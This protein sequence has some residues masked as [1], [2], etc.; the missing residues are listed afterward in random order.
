M[1]DVCHYNGDIY[2]YKKGYGDAGGVGATA[3]SNHENNLNDYRRTIS[4][5]WNIPTMSE[6]IKAGNVLQIE[7]PSIKLFKNENGTEAITPGGKEGEGGK[8]NSEGKGV[9]GLD[10]KLFK[11]AG[12]RENE[13]K[14]STLS[15]LLDRS[16]SY[17]GV[18]GTMYGNLLNL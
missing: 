17:V 3:Q 4:S 7:P 2:R 18:F 5:G 9:Y 6:K 11:L 1:E 13:N 15:D 12:G 16:K 14:L 8:I 10:K